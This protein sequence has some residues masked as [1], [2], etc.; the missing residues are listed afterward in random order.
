[1]VLAALALVTLGSMKRSAAHRA[2]DTGTLLAPESSPATPTAIAPPT[3]GDPPA[4]A[5]AAASSSAA[6][7]PPAPPPPARQVVAAP[8]AAPAARWCKVFDPERRIYVMKS[9]RIARCP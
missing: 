4:I 6:S 9:L 1:V 3:M 5:P 8:P 7:A 2:A